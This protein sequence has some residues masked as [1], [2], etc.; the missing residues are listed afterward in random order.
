[1]VPVA[2]GEGLPPKAR[3]FVPKGFVVPRQGFRATDAPA[4][5]LRDP[6]RTVLAPFEHTRQVAFA[7]ALP[8]TKTGKIRRVELRQQ[9]A[10]RAGRP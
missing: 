1:L 4:K 10:G 9:E 6:L 7:P 3:G 8:P 5:E 2:I